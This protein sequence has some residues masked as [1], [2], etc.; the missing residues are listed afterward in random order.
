[1]PGGRRATSLGAGGRGRAWM[2][3]VDGQRASLLATRDGGRTWR[4]VR[5][6]FRSS[7]Q[8]ASTALRTVLP[9]QGPVTAVARGE[10]GI[11]YASYLPHP[12]G[13]RQVIVRFDPA[14]GAAE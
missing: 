3:T 2:T 8:P 6:V 12:N 10:D 5:L 1:L 13:D 9:L 7:R 4:D 11:V 14:T